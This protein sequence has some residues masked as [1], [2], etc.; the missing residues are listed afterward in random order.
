MVSGASV[1]NSRINW[2]R[3]PPSHPVIKIWG[4]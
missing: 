3:L 1:V 4:A 2:V